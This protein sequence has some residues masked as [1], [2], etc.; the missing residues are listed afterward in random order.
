MKRLLVILILAVSCLLFLGSPV[1]AETQTIQLEKRYDLPSA[2]DLNESKAACKGGICADNMMNFQ[3]NALAGAATCTLGGLICGADDSAEQGMYIQRSVLGQTSQ[4]MAFLYSQPPASTTEYLAWMGEKA[5]IVPKTYAQGVTFSRLLPILPI[6]Q[7]FRDI[8]F[9]LLAIIMLMIGLM[10]MF[11]AKVNPQTVANVENTIPRVVV[12]I[13][14]IWL[15][16]P[17][18][19]LIIDFMYVLIAAGI[20]VIGNAVGD[21]NIRQ[22]IQDYSTGGFGTL[23]SK[24]MAPVSE[25]AKIGGLG[26]AA[27]DVGGIGLLAFLPVISI[28]PIGWVAAILMAISGIVSGVNSNDA[29]VGLLTVASPILILLIFIVL[30]FSVFKIFFMLLSAYIQILISI[31]LGP[32]YL[33]FNAIPG[34]NTFSNWW[35]GIVANMMSF[36][37]TA[38]MLYLAWAIASLLEKEPFWTPPF[39]LQGMGASQAAIGLISL[40]I[41]LL[42]PQVVAMVKQGLG[43]KSMFQVGPGMIFG[44]ITGSVGQ[45]L[46]LAGQFHTASLALPTL[47]NVLKGNFGPPQQSS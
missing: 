45:G 32:I 1:I 4:A 42:I 23:F 5:G 38:N 24:T 20:G 22:A 8:A 27:A 11:R 2:A 15:S 7:A 29:G 14:L 35:K 3:L 18:A 36:V 16:F 39:I 6:W 43:V 25:F 28:T 12:S 46:G 47:K 26:S 9:V 31:I 13:I 19:S 44:P 17:I 33:L 41:V 34:R 10:I 40:G 30:L 21:P 37:V